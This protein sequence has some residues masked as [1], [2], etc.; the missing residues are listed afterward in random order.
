MFHLGR[1]EDSA[2]KLETEDTKITISRNWKKL[3]HTFVW[4]IILLPVLQAMPTPSSTVLDALAFRKDTEG[5]QHENK[6]GM[7][8]YDGDPALYRTWKF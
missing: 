1:E 7:Y 5:R 6:N 3:A 8:V 4:R 2:V